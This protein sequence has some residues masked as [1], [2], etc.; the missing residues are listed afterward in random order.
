MKVKKSIKLINNERLSVRTKATKG[1]DST[2][3]DYCYSNDFA[4]CSVYSTDICRKQDLAPCYNHSNDV[5]AINNDT[6][7]CMFYTEDYT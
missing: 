7:S 2:S 1:C 6:T 3:T 5:C 4:T